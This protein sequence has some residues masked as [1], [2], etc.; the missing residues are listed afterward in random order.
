MYVGLKI[1][2]L[3]S[4]LYQTRDKKEREKKS[5]LT[6]GCDRGEKYKQATNF[7]TKYN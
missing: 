3:L 4:L 1:K 6:M 7:N 2:G 5:K